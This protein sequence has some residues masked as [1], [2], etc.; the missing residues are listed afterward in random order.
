MRVLDRKVARDIR[1][2]W[3]QIIAVALVMACGVA[4]IVLSVGAYRSLEETREAFYARQNFADVFATA[5]RA[6]L[7][8]ASRIEAI[9]GITGAEYRIF[10][11]VILDIADMR[12]PASGMVVSIPSLKERR[13][14]I[15]IC[16][17]GACRSTDAPMKWRLA[18]SSP[19]PMR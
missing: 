16:A 3:A 13:S 7:R 14:T 9:P 15:R 18:R 2:L 5:T 4:T 8:L 19:K 11:P 10:K 12:E 1:R 17:A 6:P